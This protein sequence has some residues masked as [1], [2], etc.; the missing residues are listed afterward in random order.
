[1][2]LEECLYK[3]QCVSDKVVREARN[4]FCNHENIG[5]MIHA[6][7]MRMLGKSTRGMT[8]NNGQQNRQQK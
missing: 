6:A 1:M 4:P 8:K 5:L 3:I 7:T 2:S